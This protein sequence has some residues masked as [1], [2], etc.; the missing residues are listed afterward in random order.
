MR[1]RLS[2]S[3]R[4]TRNFTRLC[5]NL[6]QFYILV[7]SLE[8]TLKLKIERI[9]FHLRNVLFLFLFIL[10][11]NSLFLFCF[12]ELM[13]ELLDPS[14]KSPVLSH[15]SSLSLYF[16]SVQ[17]FLLDLPRPPVQVSSSHLIHISD[18]LVGKPYV[19]DTKESFPS[20]LKS[21]HIVQ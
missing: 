20:M 3:L 21:A 9:C 10:L 18:F 4:F 15:E 12:V 17:V 8:K 13:L 14:F 6:S 16:C 11:F 2:L 7:W 19:F 1:I 5:I